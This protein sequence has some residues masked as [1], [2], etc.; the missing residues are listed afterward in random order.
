MRSIPAAN[1]LLDLINEF[2]SSLLSPQ[3][4]YYDMIIIY[5]TEPMETLF[6]HAPVLLIDNN[7]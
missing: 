5:C 1:V 7:S 3:A 2:Y 4:I 6:A